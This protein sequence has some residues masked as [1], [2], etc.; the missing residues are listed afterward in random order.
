MFTSGTGIQGRVTPVLEEFGIQD[1]SKTKIHLVK[2]SIIQIKR[3]K[4]M[5][6]IS[7]KTLVIV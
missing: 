6:H 5:N 2:I 4:G 3:K 1:K 7:F